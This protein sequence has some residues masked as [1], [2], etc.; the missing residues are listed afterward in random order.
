MP[1]SGTHT[2]IGAL[3]GAGIVATGYEN[4]NWQELG[5]IVL[6]WFVSPLVAAILAFIL[7]TNVAAWTMNTLTVSFRQRI[8]SLKLLTS[9]CVCLIS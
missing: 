8:W 4:L 6:S 3:L 2:V 7:M 1:I 5:I 9:I